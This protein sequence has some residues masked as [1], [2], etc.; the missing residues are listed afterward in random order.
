MY[1][2]EFVKMKESKYYKANSTTNSYNDS[3]S[4]DKIV[5]VEWIIRPY[6]MLP[7]FKNIFF[8]LL[9]KVNMFEGLF[10]ATFH[11]NILHISKIIK[12]Y[13]QYQKFY[14]FDKHF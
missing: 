7:N 6:S 13:I 11:N 14:Y 3:K 2:F 9:F 1:W 4:F 5:T 8:H 10:I 12:I